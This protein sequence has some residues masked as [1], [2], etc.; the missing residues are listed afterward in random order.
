MKKILL[1]LIYS[2]FMIGAELSNDDL[3]QIFETKKTVAFQRLYKGKKI[4]FH[5]VLRNFFKEKNVLWFT[6]KSKEGVVS[7]PVSLNMTQ[8]D[9]IKIGDKI[10]L[11]GTVARIDDWSGGGQ[12]ILHLYKGCKIYRR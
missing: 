11:V 1:V 8:Y 12:L 4:V 7:C 2:T 9:S 10:Q 6:T 5:G 3:P